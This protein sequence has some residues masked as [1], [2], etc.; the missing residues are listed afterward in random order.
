MK[1]A[2][3]DHP[4]DAPELGRWIRTLS[5]PES[6]PHADNLL[7]NEDSYLR[8]CGELR[9][10]APEN[11][12][13]LGVGPE[14]NLTYVAH[15]RP[16]V[17]F[18]VD[19]RRRNLLVHLLHKALLTLSPDR[20]V[21]LSRLCARPLPSA[22]DAGIAADDLLDRIGAATYEQA[23]LEE[24]TAEVA[25]ELDPLAILSH[26]DLRELGTIQARLARAGL[27]ARFLPLPGYPTLAELIR[28][29]D[30]Q[31]RPAHHLADDRLYDTL[32]AAE[33]EHRVVPLV[34]DFA[35]SG[36]GAMRRLGN[37]LHTRQ[38]TLGV[39]YLSDMEYFLLKAGRFATFLSNLE[40]LPR[41]QEAIVIRTS[42][43]PITHPERVNGDQCTT[44]IRRLEPLFVQ[45]RDGKI[46]NYENLFAP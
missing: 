40:R 18:I 13:Y 16:S 12:V 32:R 6:G 22:P 34:G 4:T 29:K 24:S 30:R 38:L 10:R 35:A 20:W 9:E 45:S 25:R 7:T 41:H 37:W 15:A 27:N 44:V 36:D 8:V 1:S 2:R 39:I 14:Q 23:R 5:E 19:Y 28:T 11:T 42:T 43:R 3:D 33:R 21:Y 46:K 31:G 26:E 17:A